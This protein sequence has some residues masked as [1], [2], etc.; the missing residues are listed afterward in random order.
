MQG[1]DKPAGPTAFF[2]SAQFT[3]PA[4]RV[5]GRGAPSPG[6]FAGAVRG[7]VA[8][9]DQDLP[10]GEVVTLDQARARAVAAPR[11]RAFLLGSFAV[12]ALILSAIGVY[13]LLSASVV[14]RTREIGVRLALGE[15]PR[16]IVAR[17]VRDGLGLTGVGLA[18]GVAL[19]IASIRVLSQFLYGVTTRS[20]WPYVTSAGVLA[21]VALA[22]SIVPA[23]RAARVDPVRSLR[24]E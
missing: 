18:I 8:E 16:R 14:Q 21:A 4:M 5:V 20:P 10:L 3:V 2:P 19:A 12:I 9:I 23:L 1:V 7:A 13:G 15:S 17:I 11:F 24:A 22:A 6:A